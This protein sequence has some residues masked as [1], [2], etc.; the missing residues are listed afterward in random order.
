[1]GADDL[2]ASTAIIGSPIYMSPEQLRSSKR[3]DGRTDVWALGVILHELCAGSPP[4]E[5]DSYSARLASIV[6]DE[7]VPL[8]AIRPDAPAALESLILQCLQKDPDKRV[9]TP[10]ALARA[11][12][13]LSDEPK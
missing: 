13:P 2:T 6:A 4:F 10:E 8:R 7:P 3:V 11:L 12:A 9:A 1:M 5:G